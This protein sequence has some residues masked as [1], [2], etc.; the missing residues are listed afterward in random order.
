[1]AAGAPI[2]CSDIHGYKGVVRRG[3]EGLLVP[4]RQPRELAVAIDRLLRD[5]SMRDQMSAAG[6][7]RA[8][9]FSWPRVT[10]KVDEYYGFVIRRLA[11]QGALPSG[12]SAEIPQAPPPVRARPS[13]A[14][15]PTS[16]PDE[17]V[18]AADS[19]SAIRH[20]QAE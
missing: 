1:M 11:A 2:V 15:P 19:A 4:P 8:E 9:E 18:L 7:A 12:F 6:R 20:S 5:P 16:A 14:S 3:R 13:A 10:A 17:A